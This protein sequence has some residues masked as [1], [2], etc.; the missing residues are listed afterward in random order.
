MNVFPPFFLTLQVINT[1]ATRTDET[2]RMTTPTIAPDINAKVSLP[3]VTGRSWDGGE[4]IGTSD[5]DEAV[6]EVLG[7]SGA[8][9][10]DVAKVLVT[11]GTAYIS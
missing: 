5:L 8:D 1:A 10:I 9:A 11:S 2:T 6:T 4:T 3:P 7:E